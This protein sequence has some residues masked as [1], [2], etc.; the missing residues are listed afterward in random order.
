MFG[1]LSNKLGTIF[2][3]LRG[4]GALTESDV[5]EAM[6]EIRIALLEAD[7]AL[8]AVKKVIADI[9]ERA[10]GH[11][12][13]KSITPGH[14]IVKIVNDHL[15][16]LLGGTISP[17]NLAAST[18]VILMVVGLQGSGKTTS[19]AKLAQF[20][21]KKERKKVLLA[22]TD[23]Y[24]PAA[25]EQLEVLAAQISIPSLPIVVGE[26]PLA[27]ALR[28][29][30][31]AKRAGADVYIIDTAGRLHM[32]E[33]LMDELVGIKAALPV[34]ETL[35]VV[36]AMTGQD[37]VTIANGFQT[38]V[39]VTGIILT[40]VDG[41][42]RGGA[43]LSMKVVT[44]CPIKFVGLGERTDQFDVFYPDRI[45][46]RI[47]GMG[48]VVGLV[49]KA[50]E[51]FNEEEA[52]K[53]AQKMSKGHF[54]LNDLASQL[55]QVSKMGGLGGM[56]QL[57][58]G[59]SK[60]QGKIQDAGLDDK[61]VARQLAMIRAMTPYER[62]SPKVLNASRKRRIA[63]GSGMQVQDLNRLLKQYQDMATLMKKMRGSSKGFLQNGLK[64]L[65]F[66]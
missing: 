35:L 43:A 46:G 36:D 51:S 4:R 55:K 38:Q 62:R 48:D 18:P 41:D 14:M 29:Y 15:V 63:A 3:R 28:G 6:R 25:Q 26:G 37:A 49:E 56:M 33:V 23:I 53:L 22:S 52:Q 64:N 59:M 11:E 54:D 60:L 61:L 45:A 2:D 65:L 50:A 47:L 39:G 44:G 40:R 12:V 9:K 17:L 58:P 31:A 66:R 32:D 27:V 34:T 42:A 57:L 1:G 16:E 30:D 20:L 13:L 10:V 7:V 19:A 8:P 5:N 24:R 21:T